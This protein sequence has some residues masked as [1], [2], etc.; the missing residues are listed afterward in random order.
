MKMFDDEVL[1]LHDLLDGLVENNLSIKQNA[2]LHFLLE[3]SEDARI[4]YILFMDLSSSLRHYAEE[5]VSDDFEVENVTEEFGSKMVSFSRYFLAIAA[6]LVFGLF[7]SPTFEG[8]FSAESDSSTEAPLAQSL[9]VPEPMVDTVAV[10]TKLV[11]LKWAEDAGFRP[12]PGN[13]LEPSSLKIE[14]GYL[15]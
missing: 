11:D 9:G 5:L 7:L 12:E 2:R 10:L 3:N 15:I 8:F 14:D 6:I 13:T 4:Q 1:E